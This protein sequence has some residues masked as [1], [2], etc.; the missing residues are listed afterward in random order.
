[1][2]AAKDLNAG[3]KGFERWREGFQKTD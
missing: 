3:S 1:M 2:L